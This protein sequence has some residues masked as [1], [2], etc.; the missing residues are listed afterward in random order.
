[1]RK[2][3]ILSIVFLGCDDR[4]KRIGDLPPNPPGPS[5]PNDP[6]DPSSPC[7]LGLTGE[8]GPATGGVV[9]LAAGDA[10]T[11]A[12]FGSGAVWCWGDNRLGSVGD[13]TDG[14][15]R[16]TPAGARG[17]TDA[18]DIAIGRERS[19][20]LRADGVAACWGMI[21]PYGF[22]LLNPVSSDVPKCM[23]GMSDG[24]AI[25]GKAYH[26]CAVLESG[27]AACWGQN[28]DGELA[29]L[30]D[31]WSRTPLVVS[32]LSNVIAASAGGDHSCALAGGEVYCWGDNSHGQLG[33]GISNE[34]ATPVPQR[35]AGLTDAIDVASG[36]HHACALRQG[37]RVA[38]WGTGDRGQLG[39][40]VERSSVPVDVPGLVG[41]VELAVGYDHN[42]VRFGDGRMSCWGR[43]D[44]LELG[45]AVSDQTYAP[46]E[47]GGLPPIEHMAL[48]ED[49]TCV[50]AGGGVYCFGDNEAGQL[51]D[52][53]LFSRP[54]PAPVMF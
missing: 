51:G 42:C 15:K 8:P 13:G 16:A 12:L 31:G 7:A 27:G 47:I 40:E 4:P 45:P 28:D 22:D 54:E 26:Y 24:T 52:G 21:G 37:G 1:M 35:V 46:V 32:G 53:S 23:I 10:H 9:A 48:G 2:F 44:R 17:L 36:E 18:V 50:V 43:G 29:D 11:C 30:S 39:V 6:S 19:C 41:A 14:N 38:C 3:I 20:A 5:D 33:A 34:G 25:S 49:H